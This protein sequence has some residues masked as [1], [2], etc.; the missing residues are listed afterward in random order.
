MLRC[1]SGA[2][3]LGEHSQDE[4]IGLIKVMPPTVQKPRNEYLN[5][6]RVLE[7]WRADGTLNKMKPSTKML[8]RFSDTQI[9]SA[10]WGLSAIEYPRSE[11]TG[12]SSGAPRESQLPG[13]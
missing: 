7:V 3:E 5:K 8:C 4:W 11:T 10:H 2:Q 12:R 1:F 9:N 13:G 6:R